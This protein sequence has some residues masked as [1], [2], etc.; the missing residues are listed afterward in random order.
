VELRLDLSD[1]PGVLSL[2]DV[3]LLSIDGHLLWVWD[4]DPE[5]FSGRNEVVLLRSERDSEVIAVMPAA[6]PFL[7]L[8]VPPAA[9]A[10]LRTGG[11]IEFQIRRDD[12]MS[13]IRNVASQLDAI[14][15]HRLL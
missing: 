2:L 4:D 3:R 13:V 9:L 10:A 12:L 6:D 15:R 11:S 14:R 8:P 7:V 5:A 1:R